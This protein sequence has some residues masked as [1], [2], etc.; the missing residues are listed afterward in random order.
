MAYT[1]YKKAKQ[2]AKA[3]TREQLIKNREL[4]PASTLLSNFR[5]VLGHMVIF[6]R[7]SHKRQSFS[8]E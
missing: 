8:G 5:L 3:M 2:V 1:K 4:D 7:E 6:P